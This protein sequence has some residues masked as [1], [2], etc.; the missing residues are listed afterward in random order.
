MSVKVK[1]S[2]GVKVKELMEFLATV[3]PDTEVLLRGTWDGE[4]DE[5]NGQVFRLIEYCL[6]DDHA[7]D[8]DVVMLDGDQ[9]EEEEEGG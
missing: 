4:G 7:N 5:P 8:Q 9:E 3:H 2:G 1:G 6:Q